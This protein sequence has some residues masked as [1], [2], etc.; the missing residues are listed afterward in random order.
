MNNVKRTVTSFKGSSLVTSKC[1]V[2]ISQQI[3]VNALNSQL[4]LEETKWDTPFE[5]RGP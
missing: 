1:Q 4:Y 3:A 5:M 2:N